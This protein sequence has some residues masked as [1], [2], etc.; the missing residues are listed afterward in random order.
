[1]W[2]LEAGHIGNHFSCRGVGFKKRIRATKNVSWHLWQ[3]GRRV[4]A[5]PARR[6]GGRAVA[7]VAAQRASAD[8]A[9]GALDKTGCPSSDCMASATTRDVRRFCIGKLGVGRFFW[10]DMHVWA[11]RN[12]FVRILKSHP[13]VT[14]TAVFWTGCEHLRCHSL[15][16]YQRCRRKSCKRANRRNHQL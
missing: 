10:V 4:G 1:M 2:F 7:P 9:R 13:G 15:R 5:A 11:W 12:K 8:G 6:G 14:V 16:M 3:P